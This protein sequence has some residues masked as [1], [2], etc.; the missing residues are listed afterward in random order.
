[1]KRSFTLERARIE[2]EAACDQEN[3]ATYVREQ[4]QEKLQAAKNEFNAAMKTYCEAYAKTSPAS[5]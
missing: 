4:A 5:S 3:K 1:M 2:H